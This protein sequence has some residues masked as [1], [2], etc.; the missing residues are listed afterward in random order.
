M[1]YLDYVNIKQGT[2][3]TPRFSHGN[4]L[5]L[6]ALPHSLA[7]FAPQ[8]NAS[9]GAWWYNPKDCSV[10]GIRLTH[11]PSPW[12]GD[13]SYFTFMPQSD[14]SYFDDNQ[15]YSGFRP[16]ETKLFPHYLCVDFLRYQ[17][18]LSLAPTDTGAVMCIRYA[19]T[20]SDPRFAVLPSANFAGKTTVDVKKSMI[21]G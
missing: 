2:D 15:R 9:R 17:A 16:H 3:S 18:S 5:P 7:A 6:T 1:K 14:G 8:T 10:E 19:D 21:Y 20:V 12:V 11:Q 4:T 13:F